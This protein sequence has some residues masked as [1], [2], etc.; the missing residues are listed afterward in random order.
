M[1]CCNSLVLAAS[2][3]LQGGDFSLPDY[4]L[5]T[6]LHLACCE[7]NYHTVK[8][9]LENGASVHS[10]DRFGHTPLIDA[11]RF[12]YVRRENRNGV[13]IYTRACLWDSASEWI[14]T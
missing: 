11:V 5:R 4:D 8:M 13:C 14:Y 6:P 7:G 2:H 12:K 3:L 1:L 10:K 9:L